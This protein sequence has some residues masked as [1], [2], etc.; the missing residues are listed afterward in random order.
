MKET[1]ERRTCDRCGQVIYNDANRKG[2]LRV[3]NTAGAKFAILDDF[4]EDDMDDGNGNF[5]SC[6]YDLCPE[7]NRKF[8]KWLASGKNEG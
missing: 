1:I 2:I 4:F 5:V 3:F 8:S 6:T 7:C